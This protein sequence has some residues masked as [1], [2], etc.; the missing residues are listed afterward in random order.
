VPGGIR[1]EDLEDLDVVDAVELASDG[2]SAIFTGATVVSTTAATKRVVLSGVDLYRDPEALEPGDLITLSGTTGADGNYTVD[3][4]V[5][6]VTFSVVESILDSTGGTCTA[7]HPPGALKVGFD[8]SGM[9]TITANNVQEALM[10]LDAG[11]TGSGLTPSSHRVL[12]QLVHLIAEDSYEEY[13]YSGVFVTSIVVWTDS[14]KT[15]KIREE[16]YTYSAGFVSQVVTKQ[17]DA[18]GTLAETLTE[19]FSYSAGQVASIDR[20]LT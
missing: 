8:P 5:D 1:K 20:E 16:L 3:A 12:D 6:G 14:G 4:I 13:T 17:Y 10:E 2:T 7:K 18:S 11:G 9:S 15:Q 19:D